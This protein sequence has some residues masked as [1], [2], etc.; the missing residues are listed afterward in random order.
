MARNDRSWFL[1]SLTTFIFLYWDF[2]FGQHDQCTG[3]SCCN[4]G[5]PGGYTKIDDPRRSKESIF[6]QGQN[7]ICDRSLAWGWYRFDSHAGKKMPNTKVDQMRC[8]TVH[9]I[10][11]KGKQ[12]T[13]Q[14]GTVDRIACI[15]FYDMLGGC[16]STLNIKARNCGGFIVY[17]LGPTH[18][19][20]LAYCA[21]KL[22]HTF[23]QLVNYMYSNF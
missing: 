10:W 7:A 23:A 5:G 12:P 13:R 1:I 22:L 6:K 3:K 15:N 19:C 16:F 18:S 14:E 20:S 2:T 11:M 8:G 17:Y 21:G 4:E 9:P